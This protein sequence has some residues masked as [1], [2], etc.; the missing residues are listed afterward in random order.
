MIP[1]LAPS[2][3]YDLDSSPSHP[4]T[5]PIPMKLKYT[6]LVLFPIL[7]GISP[8]ISQEN[9]FDPTGEQ[10][11]ANLPRQVR[12]QVEYIEMSLEE[13]S[14]L[15][16]DTTATKNDTTL[17]K[18]VAELIKNGKAKLIENQMLVAR[19]GEKSSTESIREFIYPT[20]YEPSEMPSTVKIENGAEEKVSGKALATGPTPTAFE[21]RNL[22]ATLVVEPTISDSNKFIDVRIEPELV[23]HVENTVWAEWEDKHG[24]ANIV[25]PVMY[26]MRV[27][28]AVTVATGKPCLVAALSPKD[29]KGVTDTSRKVMVFLKADV[30]VVGR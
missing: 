20:E 13:M 18:H 17:R 12:V 2:K 24:E 26:T 6:L 22:G 30:I 29:D 14:A 25:M 19:S 3:D 28:T 4:L 15:M 8:V 5:Y 16:N 7:A 21:T 1:E 10:Q 23:Y 27:N 9:Q 11:E